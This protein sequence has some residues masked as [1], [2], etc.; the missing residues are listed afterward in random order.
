MTRCVDCNRLVGP[1]HFRKYP[2]HEAIIGDVSPKVRETLV[3]Q[4]DNHR[5]YSNL[6]SVNETTK[7]KARRQAHALRNMGVDVRKYVTRQ[8]GYAERLEGADDVSHNIRK[9]RVAGD[10]PSQDSLWWIAVPVAI[11]V[12]GIGVLI[13]RLSSNLESDG[14]DFNE[15]EP[16]NLLESEMDVFT[17]ET[18]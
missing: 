18:W 13:H 1:S 16:H 5:M 17:T 14:G 4:I 7:A 15:D 8:D 12:V 6:K 9:D 10:S 2:G 11:I 3:R